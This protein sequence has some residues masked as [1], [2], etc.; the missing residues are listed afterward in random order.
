MNPQ[1][2]IPKNELAL[3]C[4]EHG[5]QRLL[6]FGSTLRADFHPES[7][8]DVLVEFAPGRSPGLMGIANME[9]KL[10]PMFGGRKVDLRTPEDLSVI[11]AKMFSMRWKL[12]MHRDDETRFLPRNKA[13][14]KL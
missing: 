8:V 14:V 13:L 2:P 1:L 5:I 6:N 12:S 7:D 3:F 9:I 10:P 4:Q 11:S